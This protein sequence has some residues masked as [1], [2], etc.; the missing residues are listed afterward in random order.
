[1][2]KIITTSELDK[3]CKKIRLGGKSI[4]LVGGVF[5]ILHPGHILFLKKAKEEGDF[6]FVLLES[7][8]KTRQ[9]KGPGRPINSQEARSSVLS[10]IYSVD[11]II[12]LKGVTKDKEYDKLL[13]QI[14]PNVIAMTKSD[15]NAIRRI[16]QSKMIGAKLKFVIKRVEDSSTTDLAKQLN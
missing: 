9:T 8:E 14:S 11:Y 7:D 13:L 3:V 15:P 12:P 5:D 2:G 16:S 1:M 6:L 4:V 10:S